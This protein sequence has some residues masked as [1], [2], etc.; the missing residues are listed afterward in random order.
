MIGHV[1]QQDALK[2]FAKIP[3]IEYLIAKLNCYKHFKYFACLS[4][5]PRCENDIVKL[6]CGEMCLDVMAGCKKMLRNLQI[7]FGCDSY[8]SYRNS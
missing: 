3:M 1:T 6:P 8:E 4:V 2:T 7:N 5:F